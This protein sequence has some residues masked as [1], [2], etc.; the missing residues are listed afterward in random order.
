MTNRY[1]IKRFHV[2]FAVCRLGFERVDQCLE[3]QT[4]N[5]KQQMQREIWDHVPFS[6][7]LSSL[8]LPMNSKLKLSIN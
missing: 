1:V 2:D 4:L 7:V 8:T 3:V 5:G 6:D